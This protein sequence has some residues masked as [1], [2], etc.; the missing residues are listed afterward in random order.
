[1]LLGILQVLS[2][3]TSVPCTFLGPAGI[4]LPFRPLASRNQCWSFIHL[5]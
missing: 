3:T 4:G 1:M 2:L 5:S